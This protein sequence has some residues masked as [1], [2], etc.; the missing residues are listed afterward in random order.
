MDPEKAE[1]K[2]HASHTATSSACFSAPMF[3]SPL[4]KLFNNIMGFA[5]SWRRNTAHRRRRIFHRDVEQDEFQ[6]AS[7]HCL[8]SY[9]SVFVVRLAIMVGDA[10]LLLLLY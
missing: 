4:T 3:I 9:Y 5:S 7:T 8:S 1:K 6:Y 10:C 2:T